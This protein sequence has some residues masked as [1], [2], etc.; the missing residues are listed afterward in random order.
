MSRISFVFETGEIFAIFDPQGPPTA[1][2]KLRAA[3]RAEIRRRLRRSITTCGYVT[4][5]RNLNDSAIPPQCAVEQTP[6]CATTDNPEEEFY[7]A[8]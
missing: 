7:V 6:G 2:Q 4:N 5:G 3:F 1:N 8:E